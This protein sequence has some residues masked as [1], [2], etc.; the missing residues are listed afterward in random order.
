VGEV[1]SLK[2]HVVRSISTNAS[3][4]PAAFSLC[5][6]KVCQT[7]SSHNS[8][9]SELMHKCS[10]VCACNVPHCHVLNALIHVMINIQIQ[11]F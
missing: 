8:A 2:C 11:V 9:V 3:E 5:N 7:N 6:F 1:L 10:A 4:Q